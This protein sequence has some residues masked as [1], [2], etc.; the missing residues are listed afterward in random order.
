MGDINITPVPGMAPVTTVSNGSA[1]TAGSGTS[2]GVSGL[3]ESPEA[4]AAAM[5]RQAAAAHAVAAEDAVVPTIGATAEG[6]AQ[7]FD[8]K[9][10]Q[11]A[12]GNAERAR[13]IAERQPRIDEAKAKAKAAEDTYEKHQFYDY[14]HGRN[15]GDKIMSRLAIALNAGVNAY[16]GIPGNELADDLQKRVAQDFEKQKVA[17]HSKENI[18][19]WRKEGVTD[20]YGQLQTELGALDVKQGKALEAVGAKA[21]AMALRAG[22]PEAQARQN[23]VTAKLAEAAS[24]K[25]LE[26]AQ[27]YEKQ[28][29]EHEEKSK[30]KTSTKSTQVT[31][32]KASAGGVEAD[33]AASHYDILKEHGNKLADMMPGLT[34]EESATINR[35]LDSKA[36]REGSPNIAAVLNTMGIDPE[37]GATPRVKEYVDRVQRASASLGRLDSGAAIG[38][39]ENL[40]FVDSFKRPNS[41]KQGDAEARAGRI[42]KDIELRGAHIARPGRNIAPGT[43]TAPQTNTGETANG[44]PNTNKLVV[45]KSGPHTGRTAKVLG[46]GKLELIGN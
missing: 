25:K 10:D 26:A 37:T 1:N 45:I 32:A 6:K 3:V 28:A 12:L 33:K 16:L 41:D 22:V 4:L 20:L 36:F 38:T 29:T 30:S 43:A 21:E 40:R 14:W 46:N 17:L 31:E 9:Q 2:T 15:S 39:T 27:R 42:K 11:I 13:L 7:G 44:T 18:A 8:L 35:V 5:A 34:P 23:V 19:K 24:A